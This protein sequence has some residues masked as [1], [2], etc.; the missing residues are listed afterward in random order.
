MSLLYFPGLMNL[1]LSPWFWCIFWSSQTFPIWSSL[2]MMPKV[3]G[4][5]LYPPRVYVLSWGPA[6]RGLN[7]QLQPLWES[8]FITPFCLNPVSAVMLGG[9]AEAFWKQWDS[10]GSNH[11]YLQFL[12]YLSPAH[13]IQKDTAERAKGES[14][15]CSTLRHHQSP[16]IFTENPSPSTPNPYH[17]FFSCWDS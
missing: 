12:P 7:L 10:V 4:L 15:C 13:H 2:L 16:L 17:K 6:S 14:L 9:S 3:S 5:C 1:Y 8:K 11:R